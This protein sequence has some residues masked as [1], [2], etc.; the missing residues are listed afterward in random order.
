VRY[1]IVRCAFLAGLAI[2]A[3]AAAPRTCA[4]LAS[5]KDYLSEEEADKIREADAPAL[6]IK[7]YLVFADDRLKK[8]EYEINRTTAERRRSEILNGLLNGYAGCI[9]DAAD[10]LAIAREKQ[11]N[12]RETLK[13]MK[14]KEKAFLEV[15]Q[16]YEKPGSEQDT[17]RDTLEDAIDGTKDAI[18]E[19]EDAEKET[20]PPPVRRKP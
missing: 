6:R 2:A 8:F 7:L 9:D 17:Y 16:K 12:V 14:E 1:Q 15:L 19:I 20:L 4:Q 3:F 13:V 10:Q 18:N 5:Q 11:M